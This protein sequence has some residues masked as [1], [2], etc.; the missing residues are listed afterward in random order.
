MNTIRRLILIGCAPVFFFLTAGAPADSI[1]AYSTPQSAQA[2]DNSADAKDEG[3]PVKSRLVVDRCS[4]CHKQDEKGRLTRISYQR[5][6]PEGWEQA[7]KRMVRLNGLSIA[8]D[9][10]RQVVKY[11][12][13]YHGL[14]PEESRAAFYEAERR[15]VE[16][17]VPEDSVRISCMLCHSLG[18]VASQRRTTEE[19]ELLVN[20]HI[21]M[22]PLITIQGLYRFDPPPG[23][24]PL[25]DSET[26]EPVDMAVE[27]FAKTYPL[28]TPE[29]NAWSA[30]IRTPKLE[31]RWLVTG[32]QLGRGRVYGEMTVEPGQAEDEFR[33]RMNLTYVKDGSGLART[34]RGIVY[35]GHSWRGRSNASNNSA[36]GEARETMLISRDW[37]TMEGRWFWGDYDEFGIDVT[38]RRVGQEPVIATLDRAALKSPSA[39]ERVTI[40][41][42]NL[43]VDLKAGEIDFGQ[44]ITVNRIVGARSDAVTVE[45][46]VAAGIPNGLHNV[47]LRQHVAAS[48]V[49]VYDKVD[50]V[51]ALPGAGMARLGGLKYPKQYQQF[52]AVAYNRGGDG[53][54]NTA[55]DLNLGA[56]D[57]EWSI[58]EFPATYNDD[59]K[60]FVG[61]IDR[62][63][64]FTPAAEGP[65]PE[66]RR[67]LNNHGDIWLVASYKPD[68]GK[69]AQP[70]KAKSFL[71]VSL[72]LYVRWDTSGV[73]R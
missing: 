45:L 42:A 72:P 32:Y 22:F 27:Y 35:A 19:W 52:E 17:K 3:I 37:S 16:E 41:G 25:P 10:A 58:E 11:L 26:R 36:P 67:S 56:V 50:Y 64:L 40:Y 54:P 43:P 59:D 30:D 4:T 47:S 62:N 39:F 55:D 8:P 24:P 71:I 38:L 49:A 65:N 18:R 69:D 7:I 68:A 48:A 2:G 14:A 70:L 9:E 53:E 33:T 28:I 15:I 60:N 20:L 12:S 73:S 29:W 57:V 31:G 1:S 44:G 5:R 61:S 63:G 66:R 13:K 51:K 6:T 23:L 21:G 34:G 46:T